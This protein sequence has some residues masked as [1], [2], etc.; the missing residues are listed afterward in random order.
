MK[1]T[2]ERYMPS[3]TNAQITYEHWHRYLFT[4]NY[5]HDKVV[6]DIACGEGYGAFYMAGYA[7]N[8]VGIDISDEAVAY[9]MST[10]KKEN[11]RF[12]QSDAVAINI[13][14]AAFADVIISFETIEHLSETQQQAF[15]DEVKRLLKPD[16]VLIMSTPD[17]LHY[18]DTPNYHNEYHLKEF[19]SAEFATFLKSRFQHTTI[20][21]QKLFPVSL[22]WTEPL[23]QLQPHFINFIENQYEIKNIFSSAPMYLIGICSDTPVLQQP[24]SVLLDENATLLA[25][26][27]DYIRSRDL[28]IV[29]LR[30]ELA[31]LQNKLQG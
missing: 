19:Y 9:A 22:I 18:T 28:A 10:Y 14:E 16:G 17:K 15:L 8:V 13:P 5:I 6:L 1:F 12:M 25:E 24:A 21:N 31:E 30:N 3:V 4:R 11:L 7:K 27:T 26:L 20:F 2:G 29:A 23:E